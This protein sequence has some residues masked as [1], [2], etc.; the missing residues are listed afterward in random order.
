M[1]GGRPHFCFCKKSGGCKDDG[2]LI[3]DESRADE[4]KGGLRKHF[5]CK[6]ALSRLPQWQTL[7]RL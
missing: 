2:E 3:A 4:G 5:C 7:M 6:M 1:R